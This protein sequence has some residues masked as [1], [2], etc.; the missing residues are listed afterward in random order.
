M[1]ISLLKIK[2][3]KNTMKTNNYIIDFLIDTYN[4]NNIDDSDIKKIII[5]HEISLL[6]FKEKLNIETFKKIESIIRLR[7]YS[8]FEDYSKSERRK[9][10]DKFM[11]QLDK[12]EKFQNKNGE[13]SI[14]ND[15]DIKGNIGYKGKA[16]SN[17]TLRDTT[18]LEKQ[19]GELKN[20]YA[21]SKFKEFSNKIYDLQKEWL[22][23]IDFEKTNDSDKNKIYDYIKNMPIS[24]LKDTNL[25]PNKS[26]FENEDDLL[27]IPISEFNDISDFDKTQKINKSD[28]VYIYDKNIRPQIISNYNP[29]EDSNHPLYQPNPKPFEF[30]SCDNPVHGGTDN[31]DPKIKPF[32][33]DKETALSLSVNDLKKAVNIKP[34]IPI[35]NYDN[36]LKIK[37]LDQEQINYVKPF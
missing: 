14:S 29:F 34:E 8:K 23:K 6:K 15:S 18:Y 28:I 36:P 22:D 3:L 7:E 11:E 26:V 9:F 33:Q 25:E 24:I 20:K 35:G 30:Y 12:Y 1:I 16:A 32:L 37:V 10:F 17:E 19:K 2:K 27:Y 13:D 31:L 21:D 5:E 4:A